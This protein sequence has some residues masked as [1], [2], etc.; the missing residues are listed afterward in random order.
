[1][2]KTESIDFL[3]KI[4]TLATTIYIAIIANGLSTE[5][6]RN[7]NKQNALDTLIKAM[8]LNASDK[9]AEQNAGQTLMSHLVEDKF[10]R[11]F[12]ATL[13]NNEDFKSIVLE[14]QDQTASKLVSLSASL[15]TDSSAS[16]KLNKP[17]S[18]WIYIGQYTNNKW[19]TQYLDG[20]SI[21]E[22][23]TTLPSNDNLT[24]SHKNGSMNVRSGQATETSL[25]PVIGIMNE[26]EK[27]KITEVKQAGNNP[28]YW[29]KLK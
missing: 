25:A 4:A 21:D 16:A 19:D 27:V 18:R 8:T 15:T 1:M 11:T 2:N 5:S 7:K 22:K 3:I 29:G 13:V 6:E 17:E 23:P 9:L 20:F 24:I 14:L 12:N 10:L 28:H 26:G